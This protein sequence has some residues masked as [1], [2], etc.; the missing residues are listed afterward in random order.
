MVWLAR[1]WLS[2]AFALFIAAS[3]LAQ[4]A[5]STNTADSPPVQSIIRK[6]DQASATNSDQP[7][8]QTAP[9]AS[10]ESGERTACQRVHTLQRIEPA[11]VQIQAVIQ[12]ASFDEWPTDQ[13]HL[14]ASH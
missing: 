13:C 5:V 1:L 2:A 8:K 6:A 4:S 7:I 12:P 3:A 10:A 9:S 11:V 14:A